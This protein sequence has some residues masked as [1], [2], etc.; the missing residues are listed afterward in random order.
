MAVGLFLVFNAQRFVQ[1]VRR[2]LL[3]QLIILGMPP[4][5]VLRWLTL[6]ILILATLGTLL[7][8]LLGSLLALALMGQLTQ[9]LADLYGPNPIDLLRLSPTSLGKA[10]VI[11]L[12]GM[13]AANL[14]GW[15]QLL[16]QSPCAARGNSRPP[17]HPWQ[18]RGLP[19]S[20]CC[21][22]PCVCGSPPPALA[23]PSSWPGLAARHG[24]PAARC[25]S[26]LAGAAACTRPPHRPA[27]G[28]RNP[29][30]PGSH[31][32]RGDGAATGHRRGHRHRGHGVELSLERGDL[33][34]PAPGRRS[35]RHRSQGVAGSRGALGEQTLNTILASPDVRA[36]SRR[37]VLPARW[38]GQPI[39]WAQ[40]DF[41]PELK[42]A[43]PL[44]AGRWPAAPDEVL[45]SEPLTVRLG[46]RVG[47]R[48]E[49][50]SEGGRGLSPR[51]RRLSGLRQR[52]GQILHAF[53]GARCNPWPSSA[54][55]P[56]TLVTGSGASLVSR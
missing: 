8:L 16:R 25:P 39:E 3:A 1:S 24:P 56:S 21:C 52:Q 33:A 37:A 49:V 23:A 22:A 51:H 5:R 38:Q 18:R 32:H 55:I 27:R 45:A 4:R 11:G 42:A 6:E 30:S 29:L 46:V 31:R 47:Q 13:L 9:A 26:L 53:E 35:L 43:Y 10:L 20:F 17:A 44:L 36:A 2:P 12:L 15:W 48:L 14:P 34:R 7:G 54:R 19:S 50:T 40:M 28:G 41:I